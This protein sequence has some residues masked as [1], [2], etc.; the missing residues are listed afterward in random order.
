[1]IELSEDMGEDEGEWADEDVEDEQG[2]A[3]MPG[4]FPQ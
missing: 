1:M 2:Q 3:A 4:A